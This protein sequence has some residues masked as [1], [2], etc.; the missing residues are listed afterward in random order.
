MV[1]GEPRYW[2]DALTICELL[3]FWKI[4]AVYL[5]GVTNYGPTGQ[6]NSRWTWATHTG[7]FL[8]PPMTQCRAYPAA[9]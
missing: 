7:S 4:C 2:G 3:R 1:I 9:T 5:A 8:N 6:V